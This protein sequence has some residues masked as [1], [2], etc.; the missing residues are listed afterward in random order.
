MLQW[1][2]QVRFPH[3]AEMTHRLA[4]QF[5]EEQPET[6]LSLLVT[7]GFD[8]QE[9]AMNA[10]VEVVLVSSCQKRCLGLSGHRF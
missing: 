6:V 10:Y 2:K 3:V 1:A 5:R 4:S 7:D 8:G 9:E